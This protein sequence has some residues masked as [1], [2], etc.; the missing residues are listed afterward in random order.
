L[1]FWV[2]SAVELRQAIVKMVSV[3]T[4]CQKETADSNSG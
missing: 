1:R 4:S 3:I 2:G